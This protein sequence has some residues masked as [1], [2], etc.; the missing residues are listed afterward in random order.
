MAVL[1]GVRSGCRPLVPDRL[2]Y[3]ELFAQTYRYP[4]NGFKKY[5][6]SLLSHPCSLSINEARQMTSSYSWPHLAAQ[7][8]D[9]LMEVTQVSNL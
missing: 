4:E 6:V 7:Y 2:S 5:L 1:E 8:Y 3:R 9:W